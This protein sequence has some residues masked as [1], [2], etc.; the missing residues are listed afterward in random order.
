[1]T[2]PPLFSDGEPLSPP[3]QAI[4]DAVGRMVDTAWADFEQHMVSG[5]LAGFPVETWKK[6]EDAARTRVG[7]RHRATF[8]VS[9]RAGVAAAM[10]V[11][12]IA[13]SE[14]MD[15]GDSAAIHAA[16]LWDDLMR[17][18]GTTAADVADIAEEGT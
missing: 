4:H 5:V 6:Y 3:E 15:A 9:Y 18:F 11:M 14:R 16:R 13:V 10:S 7:N 17:R 1:M 2:T 12:G 8:E